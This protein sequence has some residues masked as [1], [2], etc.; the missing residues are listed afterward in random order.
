MM[1]AVVNLFLLS[2]GL[3]HGPTLV[4]LWFGEI[5]KTGLQFMTNI[6]YCQRGISESGIFI[7]LD[8]K[9]GPPQL[10]GALS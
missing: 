4:P 5:A 6:I 8:G 7:V 9:V 3:T 1:L 10:G 2:T